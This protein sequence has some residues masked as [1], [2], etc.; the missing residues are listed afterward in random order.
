MCSADTCYEGPTM[1]IP[2]EKCMIMKMQVN[3]HIHLACTDMIFLGKHFLIKPPTKNNIKPVNKR[4]AAQ[5]NTSEEINHL[6]PRS[7]I[8]PNSTA[9][10]PGW[11]GSN[12]GSAIGENSVKIKS[13]PS[14]RRS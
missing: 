11:P 8:R 6:R 2:Y 7:T 1:A 3:T 14:F 5:T 4:N 10:S 12:E 9:D 13:I